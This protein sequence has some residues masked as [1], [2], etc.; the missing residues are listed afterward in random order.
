[1]PAVSPEAIARSRASSLAWYYRK[2]EDPELWA[3]HQARRRRSQSLNQAKK[4]EFIRQYKVEKGCIDCG[5]NAHHAALDLDHVRGKKM[6][7]MGSFGGRSWAQLM[8]EL[9]KCEVRCANCHRL[10]TWKTHWN[11]QKGSKYRVG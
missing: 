4:R 9:E 6:F 5:Y 11:K 7:T 3:E 10:K 1:M 8:A 2:K